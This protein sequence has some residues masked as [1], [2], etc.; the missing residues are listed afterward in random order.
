MQVRSNY[1]AGSTLSVVCD[2]FTEHTLVK[3]E[4][5]S[6]THKIVI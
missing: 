3:F 1:K 4:I 5:T 2:T 6:G